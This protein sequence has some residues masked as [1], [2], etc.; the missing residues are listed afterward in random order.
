MV[1]TVLV[2]PFVCHAATAAV[3]SRYIPR[4]ADPGSV[5]DAVTAHREVAGRMAEAAGMW[6]DSL[7]TEQ[8]SIGQGVVPADD[9]TDNERR[10]WFY[11]PTDHGGLTIHQQR[12]AQQ[13]LS[14][15]HI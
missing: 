10:R 2:A 11:T 9:P 4:M 12:P 7:D 5:R 13:R 3:S 1:D 8:R 14:L 15:I 6:L